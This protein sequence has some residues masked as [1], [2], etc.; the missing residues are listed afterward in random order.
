MLSV[1]PILLLNKVIMAQWFKNSQYYCSS[2]IQV[3]TIVMLKHVGFGHRLIAS[4]YFIS[5]S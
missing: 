2:Y 5:N 1:K 4:N 3:P